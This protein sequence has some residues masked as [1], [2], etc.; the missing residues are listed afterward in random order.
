MNLEVVK[1]SG[2]GLIRALLLTIFLLMVL[3]LTMNFLDLSQKNLY[4]TYIIITCVS[5]VFGGVY[6]ARK[7]QSK[8]WLVGLFVA[9]L[10]YVFIGIV[11]AIAKGKVEF[12]SFDVY[13]LF[14][15]MAIGILSGMLG[16]NI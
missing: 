4:V 9:I 2:R 14:F 1:N 8:G 6:G 12:V 3:A 5:I 11:S 15:A 10:Y 13:R 16:I 7:N